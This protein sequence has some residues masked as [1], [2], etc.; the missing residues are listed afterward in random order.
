MANR[1]NFKPVLNPPKDN[2][3]ITTAQPEA[4]LP[5]AMEW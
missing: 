4:A 3:M 2:A 5:F 1:D